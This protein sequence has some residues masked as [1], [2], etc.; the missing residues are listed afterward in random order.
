[1]KVEL[2]ENVFGGWFVMVLIGFVLIFVEM[3]VWVEFLLVD[4]YLVEGYGFIEVGMVL[5]DGMVWCFV[6]IDYKLVD[7]FELG[8]F[9]ID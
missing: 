4:V 7:V 2:W 6:V 9:G 3:M 8:Y 1:M 5:N